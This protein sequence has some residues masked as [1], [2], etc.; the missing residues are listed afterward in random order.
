MIISNEHRVPPSYD[1]TDQ[2]VL[3]VHSLDKT[4]LIGLPLPSAMLAIR[5]LPFWLMSETVI[6]VV[7][8]RKS[9]TLVIVFFKGNISDW[10]S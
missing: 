1:E 5:D 9:L 2:G 10:T 4:I 7:G 8:L 6:A 3:R